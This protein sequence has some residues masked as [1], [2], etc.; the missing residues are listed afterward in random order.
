M[1]ITLRR[2][3][4]AVAATLASGFFVAPVPALAAELE[5]TVSTGDGRPA[6]A[7]TVQAIHATTQSVH[8]AVADAQGRYRIS[9]LVGGPYR[10]EARVG[11]SFAVVTD[12]SLGAG[13][14]ATLNLRLRAVL[15]VDRVAVTASS[16]SELESVPGGV[17]EIGADA[18]RGS[19]AGNLK[20][21]MAFTPGLLVQ[22][23]FGAEESQ[24]SVRGSGLRN[25][26][27]HRSLNLFVN[28]IP[29]QDADGFSDFESIELM[30][31][32]RIE[33]WKGA[34]ALEYGANSSG[35]ALNFV[36]Y[37]GTTAPSLQVGALGGSFGFHK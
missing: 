6:S 25:N 1:S 33:L 2:A 13:E 36:T 28:G 3:L 24:L 37:Q 14:R 29:Y 35:G 31:T 23:R 5:G 16:L 9:G 10:V 12:V 18:I 27:H 8:D 32:Q 19:R 20:D 30:S 11:D 22:P 26:F 17:A 7:A 34:N 4:L 21:V 15:L